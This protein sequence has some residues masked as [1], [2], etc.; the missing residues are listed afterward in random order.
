MVYRRHFAC[1]VKA[2]HSC[3]PSTTVCQSIVLMTRTF[4]T[5]VSMHN[6]IHLQYSLTIE[7]LASSKDGCSEL[8]KAALSSRVLKSWGRLTAEKSSVYVRNCGVYGGKINRLLTISIT[9]GHGFAHSSV[10]AQYRI[11]TAQTNNPRMMGLKNFWWHFILKGTSSRAIDQQR[12]IGKR[13]TPEKC[14]VVRIRFAR[15]IRVNCYSFRT[16]RCIRTQSTSRTHNTTPASAS[17]E[18][19]HHGVAMRTNNVATTEE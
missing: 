11:P 5:A 14:Y 15:T 8:L 16:P 3:F 7:I 9:S 12:M 4:N 1:A 17:V 13:G 18:P 19:G 10:T 6:I 2:G